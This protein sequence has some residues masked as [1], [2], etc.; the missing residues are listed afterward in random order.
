MSKFIF[1]N[2]GETINDV[3]NNRNYINKTDNRK[4]K[5]P[6]GILLPLRKGYSKNES[7][8][9]MSFDAN[10]QIKNNFKNFLMI[11]KGEMIGNP[12]FGTRLNT[13]IN[14]TNVDIAEIEGIILSEIESGIRQYFFN[15]ISGEELITIQKLTAEKVKSNEDLEDYVKID[16]D[17]SILNSNVIDNLILNFKI[18]K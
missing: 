10:E 15:Q 17:F 6:I 18:N 7:L 9:K 2:V 11:R 5:K 4:D 8:F 1:K 13:I 16:I 14:L 12:N 3:L